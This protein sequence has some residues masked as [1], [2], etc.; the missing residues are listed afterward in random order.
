VNALAAVRGAFAHR[1]FQARPADPP[2]LPP[3][4]RASDREA[5]GAMLRGASGA[6]DEAVSLR[7]LE[8]W[9]VPTIPH[10]L[11][12]SLGEARAA[13]AKLGYPVACKTAEPGI[14]HKSDVGGVRLDLADD[15]AL[16]EAYGDL[17]LRLGPRALI[18]SMAGRGVEL[19]LGMIRDPQFGPI[20][21]VGAGGT[22]VEL[23]DDRRAALAPFGP[24]TAR[25][26]LDGLKLRRLL[27]GYRGSRPV[28]MDRLAEI[29][30]RFS[31]LAA[32]LGG[33]IAEID[34]NP[35]IATEEIL[36]LDALIVAKPGAA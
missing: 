1:D 10:I 33:L 2:P 23:L 9:G 14:L 21:T 26:L 17:V 25:R 6:L 19:S 11:V 29:V 24:A 18:A 16:R 34:V 15:H 20:V 7:L 22:L 30:A 12:A 3:I 28:D 5:A 27:D 8:A 36:A 13:A 4:A 35:L 31:V 32:E